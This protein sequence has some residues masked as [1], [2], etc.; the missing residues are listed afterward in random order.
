[1]N[2]TDRLLAIILELQA[3]GWQRAEDLGR[4]FE[5]SK[6]TVYRD[7]QALA[8]AGVPVVSSPG[9]G[10]RLDE[11][12]FLPPLSFTTDEAICLVLGSD[13]V[14]KKFDAQYRASAQSALQKINAVFAP[15]LRAE[16]DDLKNSLRFLDV[17]DSPVQS[18]TLAQ[19]RRAIIQRQRIK[20]AYETRYTEAETR[21]NRREVDP[22]ALVYIS[23]AWYVIGYCHLRQ[24]IRFFRLERIDH[25]SVLKTTFERPADF[26]PQLTD[27]RDRAIVV[28]AL[29]SHDVKRWVREDPG[30]YTSRMEDHPDGLLVTLHVRREQDILSW[31]LSWGRQVRVLSPP[32]LQRLLAEEAEAV[33]EHY[34]TGEMLLP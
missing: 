30:F 29:F 18:E 23:K 4:T 21:H 12:Y 13:F 7:M 14:A 1:M 20:I 11:G 8:E 19:L 31:L 6:R 15:R 25:L 32:S 3:R 17:N 26:T 33:F 2:R 22:Y 24:D 28:K 10:Y 16:V 34:K 27:I 5:I 9:Q